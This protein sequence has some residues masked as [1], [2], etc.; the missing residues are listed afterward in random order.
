LT[1]LCIK[2]DPDNI[3]KL[4]KEY[5]ILQLVK[6][7]WPTNFQIIKRSNLLALHAK[8]QYIIHLKRLRMQF[9]ISNKIVQSGNYPHINVQFVAS[10]I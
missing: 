6:A 3:L 5:R 2:F 7:I 9:S 8:R 10:G 1:H 4:I